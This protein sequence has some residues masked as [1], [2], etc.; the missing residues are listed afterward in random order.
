M[1][2]LLLLKKISLSSYNLLISFVQENKFI[3]CQR[4]KVEWIVLK[5]STC[6]QRGF[7][8]RISVPVLFFFQKAVHS[9]LFYRVSA[10]RSFLFSNT[11]K[12]QPAKKCHGNWNWL[13]E[14]QLSLA[15]IMCR[16][17]FYWVQSNFTGEKLSSLTVKKKQTLTYISF[18]FFLF[19][20]HK[21]LNLPF[22]NKRCQATVMN[23][24]WR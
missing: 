9:F 22:C 23:T 12:E 8:A 10:D 1:L 13:F 18:C 2:K 7:S 5:Y 15:S 17:F 16:F 21:K 4:Q 11:A 19:T 6:S 20:Q 3:F 14:L 24:C